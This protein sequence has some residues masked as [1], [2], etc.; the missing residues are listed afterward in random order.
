MSK[1]YY[2]LKNQNWYWSSNGQWDNKV[3]R[4]HFLS[5]AAAREEGL[6]ALILFNNIPTGTKIVRVNVKTKSQIVE[7]RLGKEIANLKKQLEELKSANKKTNL[8]FEAGDVWRWVDEKE[9]ND[10]EAEVGTYVF[11][12][13]PCTYSESNNVFVRYSSREDYWLEDAIEGLELVERSG[14]LVK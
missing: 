10:H 12:S 8:K 5:E 13:H 4:K 6:K 1:Y 14:K 3:N 11:I 7:D 9:A 2:V